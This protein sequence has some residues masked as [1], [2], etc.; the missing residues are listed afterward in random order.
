[1][2]RPRTNNLS[3]RTMEHLRRWGIAGGSGIGGSSSVGV[4][5]E[6]PQHERTVLGIDGEEPPLP[7]QQ[8][9]RPNH[10]RPLLHY[11][12]CVVEDCTMVH[13][14]GEPPEVKEYALRIVRTLLQSDV[15]SLESAIAKY[16]AEVPAAT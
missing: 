10:G 1:M 13:R 7:W 8:N 14:S 15:L 9:R 5:H 2:N 6:R 16:L 4:L 12:V 11:T 3:I